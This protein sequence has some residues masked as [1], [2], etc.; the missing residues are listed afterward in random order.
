VNNAASAIERSASLL[1]DH[2]EEAERAA[3]ALGAVRLTDA[4][5]AAVDACAT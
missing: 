2:L 5:L 1:E 4:P 3:R